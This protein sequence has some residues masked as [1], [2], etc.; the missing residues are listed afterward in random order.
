MLKTSHT[1]ITKQ[2][3]LAKQTVTDWWYFC[4]DEIIAYLKKKSK[5]KIGGKGRIVEIDES[6]FGKRKY[7]RGHHVE[8]QWVFGGIERGSGRTFLVTVGD[9]SADTLIGHIKRWIEPET[10]IISD[11]WA[12]YKSIPQAGYNHLTV[13]HSI[14]FV[15]STT[16]AHTNTIESTWKHVKVLMNPYNRKANYDRVLAAYL[17][18]KRCKAENI[19]PFCK[20]MDIVAKIDFSK[21]DR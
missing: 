11:C 4:S 19:D 8:G 15:D 20:F 17:F 5:E 21:T 3:H 7:N 13:N 18:R 1:T 9:R 10:T 16:G 6:K 2:H 14:Q 12:A